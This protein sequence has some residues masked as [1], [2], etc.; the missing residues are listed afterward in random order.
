MPGIS[1]LTEVFDLHIQI[2]FSQASYV[3]DLIIIPI[4]QRRNFRHRMLI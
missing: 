2:Q 1:S 3:R 4:L